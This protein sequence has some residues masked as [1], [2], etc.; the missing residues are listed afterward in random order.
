MEM[1]TLAAVKQL[2]KRNISVELLCADES[3]IHIEANNLGLLVHPIK[4]TWISNLSNILRL[5]SL[6]RRSKYDLIHTQASFDLWLIVP[7]LQLIKKNIPLILTKQVG[8]FIIKK[9]FLHKWIYN[10]VAFAFAISTAIQKNLVDTC[11]LPTDK[12]LLVP[13]GIDIERFNPENV[14]PLKVRQ[15]FEIKDNE[16][17]IGMMARFSPGKGHE[18]FLFA[19][20]E[21]NKK[22]SSLKFMAVGEASRGENDYADSIK[23]LAADYQLKNLIFTGYRSDTPDILAAL[24]IFVFPSHAEAFGIALAE[25]MAMGKPSVC[26]NAEGILDIAV[27]NETSL[28]FENKNA[29][30]LTKKISILIDSSD[31]RDKFSAA[32]RK[33][34]VEL[35]DLEKLTDKTVGIYNMTII[36]VENVSQ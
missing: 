4:R 13:N 33:R 32:A 23:K 15:E 9:D 2:L 17:L 12:V 25:A 27:D 1:F 36:T 24:N 19:A 11:P 16:L 31:L 26:S 6:I 29:E 21:L 10:R 35:F 18:E 3:R 5:A 14:N 34:A 8:S 28:L 20:K 7:A 30:D 22:Y